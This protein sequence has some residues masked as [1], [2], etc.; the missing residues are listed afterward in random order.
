MIQK[1]EE[2]LG[3]LPK[4]KLPLPVT[5]C[6]SEM[7][8]SPLL[9]L[10]DH[11]TYQVLLGMLQWNYTIGRIELGPAVSSLNR[12]GACP[13]KGHLQLMKHVFSYLKYSALSSRNIAIDSNPMEYER[14]ETQYKFLI[15]NFL[16]DYPDAK[17][18][19]DPGFTKPYGQVLETTI[20]IDSD[21]A[22]AKRTRQSLTGLIVFVGSTPVYWMSKQQLT[23]A[24][25]TYAA[26][27]SALRTA[28]EEEI[29][30]QYYLRCLGVNIPANGTCPTKLF[31]DNLS[32]I[33]SASNP[34]HDLSKKHVAISFHVVCEAIAADIVKPYWLKGAY[35]MSDVMTK[36][37]PCGQ[38]TRHLNY[39]Y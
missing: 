21:H 39:I 28:T 19:I 34:G 6:H 38:F 37:I 24:S 2:L 8:T 5:D 18:E 17:E 26:E 3:C 7:D 32:V 13:Q 16:Q 11:R 1:A 30:I 27:F 33:Q 15:P 22:H 14:H 25:S 9:D 12:F 20:L 23:V 10:K 29:N 31:G 36:Q 35:N 4:T